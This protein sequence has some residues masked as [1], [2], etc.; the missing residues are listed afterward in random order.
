M[1]YCKVCG[2]E[3]SEDANFCPS[4]GYPAENSPYLSKAEQ[5]YKDSKGLELA[6]KIFLVIGC[7]ILGFSILGLLWG[8]PMTVYAFRQLKDHKHI[9]VAFKVCTLLFLSLVAG[10]LLLFRNEK[11]R[12]MY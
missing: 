9:G 8:V 12:T 5:E 11:G 2:H 1:K 10:I 7:V 6:I 3:L 4:C